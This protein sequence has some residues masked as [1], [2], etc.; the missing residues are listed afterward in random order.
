[1][2]AEASTSIGG[3]W[4]RLE[5]Q[6]V[7]GRFPLRRYLGSTDRSGVFLTES[8]PPAPS[9]VA[10]KLVSIAS[11]RAQSQLARWRAAADISHAHLVRLFDVG[12]CNVGGLG[13]LYAVMEYADQDLAQLLQSRALTEEETREMLAPTL[14]ALAFLH[15][16]DLVLGRMKPSNLL[17]VGDQLKLASDA[18]RP[19][20]EVDDVKAL[21]VYDPPEARDGICSTASDVWAL[22]V[23]ICE[24]LTCRQPLGLLGG[25]GSVVLPPDFPPAFRDI[26]AWCLRRRPQ[27]RPA[28]EQINAWLTG[29]HAA[30][31][32]ELAEPQ[33]ASEFPGSELSASAAG[34]P[35]IGE[36]EAASVS[37]S[38][39]ASMPAT[40]VDFELAAGLMTPA[41][42]K[43][44]PTATTVPVVSAAS[45]AARATSK[46]ASAALTADRAC[47]GGYPCLRHEAD[48]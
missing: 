47:L 46:P 14:S 6:V 24:A 38:S 44:A 42:A 7:E 35:P 22:G 32:A 29:Q 41:A 5:G 23:V 2:S 40:P 31:D 33:L 39:P 11:P 19:A 9:E 25:G 34:P 12:Q 1:M 10:L 43:V 28:V 37:A 48:F 45:T 26:V 36:P 30:P 4:A 13:N 16:R 21:S 27:D 18:I 8:A 3:V 20:G 17:V 15:E